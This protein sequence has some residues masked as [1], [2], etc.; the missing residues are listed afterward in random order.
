MAHSYATQPDQSPSGE[1]L[2]ERAR[3]LLP[4]LHERAGETESRRQV[5]AETIAGLREAGL[6]HVG[7]PARFG[8]YEIGLDELVAII[9]EL[10]TAC[11]STGWVYGVLCDHNITM[12]MF[13][14]EAQDELWADDRHTL[15]SS[16]IAPAG[17][18][19]RADGG[20]RL[21]G[22][23]SFSSGCDHATWVFVQSILPP[24]RDGDPP[25]P[26][27]FLLP[28]SDYGIIDNWYVMGLAGTGSKDIEID[29]AFVPAHRTLRVADAN[30]GTGPGTRVNDGVLYR[31]PRTATVPFSLVAPA[32]G[33]ARALYDAY[34]AN[35]SAREAR[36]FKLAEQATI[37]MR[38]AEASAE[39]DAA[40]LMMHRACSETMATMRSDGGLT[41]EQRARNRRDMGYVVTLCV[42]AAD[43][44]FQTTGGA[45]LYTGNEMQRMFRDVRAVS[46]HYINSWD[47]AGTTFGRVAL[48]LPPNHFA[49]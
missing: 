37:Q 20:Y 4:V 44:L 15:I 16:G 28:R 10:A 14:S 41:L 32:V 19:A 25:V 21:S 24:E 46:A 1:V 6:F 49:I 34:I 36:G 5:S 27:Y 23:W 22:R 35:M 43:R 30:A 38:V 31:L 2:L 3:A 39:I 33:I 11:G 29:D 8:G 9:A 48:G 47:I 13:P 26:M 18:A 40:R 12:G 45:G 42:R 7:Q 17:N